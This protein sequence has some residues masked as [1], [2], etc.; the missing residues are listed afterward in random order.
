MSLPVSQQLTA[1]K[2]D[3]SA[4]LTA[5]VANPDEESIGT[6][7][8]EVVEL[9]RSGGID[10]ETALRAMALRRRDAARAFELA[11]QPEA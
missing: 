3:L 4:L 11:N 7:L 1:Q 2:S 9:A 10:P 6:L 8:M 5:A